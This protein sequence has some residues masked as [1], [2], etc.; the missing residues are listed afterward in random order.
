MPPFVLTW[1]S[2]R[3]E[4]TMPAMTVLVFI[5][6]RAIFGSQWFKVALSKM[7][8]LLAKSNSEGGVHSVGETLQLLA[9]VTFKSEEAFPPLQYKFTVSGKA[10]VAARNKAGMHKLANRQFIFLLRLFII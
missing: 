2:V 1:Y 6:A 3:Y 9:C 7:R 10:S 4:F 8:I 5:E